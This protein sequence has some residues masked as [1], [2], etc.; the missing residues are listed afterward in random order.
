[1]I[2]LIMLC[3]IIIFTILICS[4]ID[5]YKKE[6]QIR[7]FYTNLNNGDIVNCKK[8][9]ISLFPYKI[10]VINYKI[11]IIAKYNY[12]IVFKNEFGQKT[13]EDMWTFYNRIDNSKLKQKH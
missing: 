7:N 11:K 2:L 12:W 1:M 10:K 6:Q 8:K 3:I 5:D 9:T 4:V 13:H